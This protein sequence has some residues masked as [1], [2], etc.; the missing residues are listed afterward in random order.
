MGIYKEKREQTLTNLVNS[1]VSI[2]EK[3][4]INKITIKEITD[5][6]GYN[7][8][9]FYMYFKDVYDIL[10]H[11][12]NDLFTTFD[13]LMESLNTETLSNEEI[14]KYAIDIFNKNGE[15]CS[16]LLSPRGDPNFTILY[17]EKL[18]KYLSHKIKKNNSFSEKYSD[19]ILEFFIAG[20]I[21]CIFLW[22]QSHPFPVHDLLFL[23]NELIEN[24]PSS[25]SLL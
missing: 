13:N 8:G 9:T 1:F 7:R 2:Y 16:L 20:I 11:I 25:L 23:L 24:G 10:Q 14:L 21:N 15:Q 5:K 12:E 17:K 3:K 4:D 6:A 18:K 22:H 19:F